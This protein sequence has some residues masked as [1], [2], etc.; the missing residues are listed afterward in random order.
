VS[1]I[2]ALNEPVRRE[3]YLYVASRPTEVSRD[4]AA[5]AC[6]VSRA[7]AAFHLDKLVDEGLLEPTYRRLTGRTGPGAGRPTKLYRRSGRQ[8]SVTLPPRSYELAAKL[9]AG[10][11]DGAQDTPERVKL[12]EIA[13]RFGETVGGEAGALIDADAGSDDLLDAIMTA[14]GAYGYEPYRDD[15]GDVRMRNC[16]FHALASEHRG[17]VCGMNLQLMGG[18]V[19]GLGVRGVTATLELRPNECCVAFRRNQ[20]DEESPPRDE[21]V[22]ERRNA[23]TVSS[24]SQGQPQSGSHF[25][26]SV[27]GGQRP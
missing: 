9:F 12:A 24:A 22:H 1:G 26:E 16:P 6:G 3:L 19:E 2:A 17:L 10:A 27:D 4:E 8:V 7:L 23:D 11:L 13:R 18:V 21:P 15:H 20:P 14:L 5:A 25:R